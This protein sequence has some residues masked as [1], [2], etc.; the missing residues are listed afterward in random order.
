ML[1][2]FGPD[3]HG[4]VCAEYTLP[5]SVLYTMASCTVSPPPSCQTAMRYVAQVSQLLPVP[6][7]VFR[8]Y[9]EPQVAGA[10]QVEPDAPIGSSLATI[11]QSDP[12]DAQ[13]ASAC[14]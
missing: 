12:S 3:P 4:L 13:Y 5:D 10:L 1:S 9:N 6:M 7:P 2:E 14:A 11:D 8:Q